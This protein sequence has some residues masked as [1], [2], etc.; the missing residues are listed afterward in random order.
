MRTSHE[1]ME[2]IEQ[3]MKYDQWHLNMPCTIVIMIHLHEAP[4][5]PVHLGDIS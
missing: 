2:M 3:K 5:R 4:N 1:R